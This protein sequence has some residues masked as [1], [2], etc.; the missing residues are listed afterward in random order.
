MRTGGLLAAGDLG[1]LRAAALE[2]LGIARLPGF[3]VAGA[4]EEGSLAEVLAD[5]PSE[6]EALVAHAAAPGIAPA[7]VRAF[8]DHLAAGLAERGACRW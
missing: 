1:A 6:P 4:I 8:V 3:A 5:L 2:G 7:K